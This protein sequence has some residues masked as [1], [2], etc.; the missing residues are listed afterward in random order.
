M[1]SKPLAHKGFFAFAD[2][3]PVASSG[4]ENDRDSPQNPPQ[5]GRRLLGQPA[6]E[7]G[8]RQKTVRPRPF[9]RISE[10]FSL[11]FSRT[12]DWL[13]IPSPVFL[14]YFYAHARVA[15]RRTR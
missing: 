15:E 14:L 11:G 10:S 3:L 8:G 5:S 4:S 2:W 12:L 13:V 6:R 7:V 1:P 9:A